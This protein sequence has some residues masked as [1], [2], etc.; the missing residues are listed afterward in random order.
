[1]STPSQPPPI[2][3]AAPK[4]HGCFFYGCLTSII[5]VIILVIGLGGFAYYGLSKVAG[6]AVAYTDTEAVQLPKVKMSAA[7][8][9]TLLK[10]VKDFKMAMD[11]GKSSLLM[12]TGDELNALVT[13]DAS[14]SEWKGRVWFEIKDGSV[15]CQLSMPL[16]SMA[17][18][19]GLGALKGR[20]LNGSAAVL[21]RMEGG[22]LKVLFQSMEVRSKP[23]PAQFLEA[24]NQQDLMK[25]ASDDPDIAAFLNRLASVGVQ[26]NKLILVGKVAR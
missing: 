13:G 4:K 6:M 16:N 24:F 26:D 3:T 17:V 5:V 21:P 14:K 19:P 7:D 9:E 2:P 23:L 18:M 1:M 15:K 20:Y 25:S 12:L 11:T 8:Y 22:A 10:R